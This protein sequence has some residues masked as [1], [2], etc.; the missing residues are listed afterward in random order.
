MEKGRKSILQEAEE[1]I[2]EIAQRWGE[3]IGAHLRVGGRL[4]RAAVV[5]TV[6]EGKTIARVVHDALA[7]YL[8]EGG[9]E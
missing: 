9:L 7:E 3:L 8:R 5:R 6:R 1:G 4:W 2:R